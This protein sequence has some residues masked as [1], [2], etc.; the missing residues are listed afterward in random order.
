MAINAQSKG[1]I[2]FSNPYDVWGFSI[3]IIGITL[4]GLIGGVVGTLS[5]YFIVQVGKKEMS[6]PMKIGLGSLISVVGIILY[7]ILAAI[8]VSVIDPAY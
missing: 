2:D 4:G 6:K 7:V 1:P 5:G 3:G 8:L